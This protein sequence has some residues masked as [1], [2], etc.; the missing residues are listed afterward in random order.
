MPIKQTVP[1]WLAIITAINIVVGGSFFLNAA[2]IGQTAGAFSPLAWIG[3]G[4][5]LTPLVYMLARLST[6]YPLA[7]GLYVYSKELISPFAGFLSGWGYFVGTAAGNAVILHGCIER[8][9]SLNLIP[10]LFE[11]TTATLLTFDLGCIALVLLMNLRNI[12]LLETIQVSLTI[13]KTIPLALVVIAL[14]YAGSWDHV[15]AAPWKL[16]GMLITF[17]K[18]IFSYIGIEAC[19]SLT[20]T[21][22]NPTRNASRVLLISFAS[23][24]A[25]YA[26]LQ[27]ALLYIHGHEANELFASLVPMVVG[28][29]PRAIIFGKVIIEAAIIIS[30]LGGFYSMFYANNWNLFAIGEEQNSKLLTTK[31]RY[32]SPINS[33]LAQS[34]IIALFL[35]A[36]ASIP[37][38]ITMSDFGT[39]IAYSLSCIAFLRLVKTYRDKMIGLAGLACCLYFTYLCTTN[40][41]AEGIT[42]VIPFLL[43]MGSGLLI[44]LMGSDKRTAL[45]KN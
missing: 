17:P 9:H 44:L 37:T 1:A 40:L 22:E 13:L 6:V 7:G 2:L 20:H 41:L 28:N 5:L 31:N 21:L 4:A 43:L 29:S 10:Q 15:A 30:F 26:F 18:V 24:V 32:G 23:I 11:S 45:R 35:I 12:E 38:L 25:I 19:C 36:G 16:D 33:L 27:M 34:I 3:V 42:H 39:V 8:L 14:F